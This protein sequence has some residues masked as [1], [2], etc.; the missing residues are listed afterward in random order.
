M[1]SVCSSTCGGGRRTRTRECVN[2]VPGVDGCFGESSDVE[3]CETQVRFLYQIVSKSSD[4]AIIY[5]AHSCYLWW[6]SALHNT[7]CAGK[8]DEFSDHTNFQLRLLVL[9]L[10]MAVAEIPADFEWKTALPTLRNG[11]EMIILTFLDSLAHCPSLIL[12]WCHALIWEANAVSVI[13]CLSQ[14]SIFWH[15]RNLGRCVRNQTVDDFVIKM[16]VAFTVAL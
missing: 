2:G 6:N 16:E 1:W 8:I 5:P 10:G 14:K 12:H 11:V 4:S 13:K 3:V 15:G 9:F 7:I